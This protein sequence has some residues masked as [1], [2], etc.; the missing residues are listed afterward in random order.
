MFI[1]QNNL[2]KKKIKFHTE[3]IKALP[4]IIFKSF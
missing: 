1:E 2:K 4:Q 3:L